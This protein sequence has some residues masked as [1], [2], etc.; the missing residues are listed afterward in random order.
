MRGTCSR[1]QREFPLSWWRIRGRGTRFTPTLT[2]PIKGEENTVVRLRSYSS[3]GDDLLIG[4]PH[5]LH[6]AQI[7][8]DRDAAVTVAAPPQRIIS[9]Y[10][11][12]TET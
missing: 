4:V 10:G 5:H 8:D 6:A 3:I 11:G 1:R 9:L 12:L 2:S 7:T